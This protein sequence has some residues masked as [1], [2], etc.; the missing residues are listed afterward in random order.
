MSRRVELPNGISSFRDLIDRW[1]SAAAFARDAGA[2]E[3]SGRI[4]Y[5]RDR[6]PERYRLVV[7]SLAAEKGIVLT[8]TGFDE[9]RRRGAGV[10]K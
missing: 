8:T 4:W 2:N 10:G 7:V 9:L 1:P 6:V 5:R 3:D